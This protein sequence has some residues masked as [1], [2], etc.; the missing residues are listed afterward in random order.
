MITI[1]ETVVSVY[2]NVV[3]VYGNDV[4]SIVAHDINGN[5]INVDLALISTKLTE[6]QAAETAAQQAAVNA[7]T[8]AQSKLAALGLTADE[9]KAILGVSA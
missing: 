6:L 3:T 7:K 9:V 5:V 2:P 8:S 4:N 1:Y